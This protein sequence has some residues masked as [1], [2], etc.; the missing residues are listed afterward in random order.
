MHILRLNAAGLYARDLISWSLGETIYHIRG[1]WNRFSGR[2]S[3]IDLPSIVAYH[4]QYLGSQKTNPPLTNR[5]LFERDNLQ[6]LYCG[7]FFGSRELTRDNIIPRSRGGRDK[8]VN[9][10]SACRRC[11]QYKGRRSLQ[12][13]GSEC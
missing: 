5:A 4:G 1:G 2:R 6:C 7:K 10:V 13:P 11:N 9:V 3:V 8:W 12:D